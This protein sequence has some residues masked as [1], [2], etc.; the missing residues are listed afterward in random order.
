M[1]I[2][3]KTKEFLTQLKIV[4][5]VVTAKTAI[6]ILSSVHV[7]V[8]N[9]GNGGVFAILQ[10]SDSEIWL[11]KRVPLVAGVAGASFCINA[12]NLHKALCNLEDEELVMK[13]DE[14]KNVATCIYGSGRFSMPYEDAQ[15]YPASQAIMDSADT[16]MV[17][18]SQ[19]LFALNKVFFAIGDDQLRIILNGV[20]FDCYP[21]MMVAVA[22]DSHKLAVYKDRKFKH[23]DDKVYNFTLPEK[24]CCVLKSFIGEEGMVKISVTDK[25]V[26]FSNSNFKLTAR[27]IEGNYPNY[28]IVTAQKGTDVAF[29]NKDWMIAALKRVM[30]MGNSDSQLVQLGFKNEG[31]LVIKTENID[32][33]TSATEAVDC[34]YTGKDMIIGFKASSLIQVLTNIYTDQATIEMSDPT[35]PCLVYE[36]NKDEY[37]SLIMPMLIR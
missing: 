8:V 37:V 26:A 35:R 2:K 22:T 9:D 4:N 13:F 18:G 7:N 3:F 15:A 14:H 30:P 34:E 11:Q 6:P 21:E 12:S 20:H 29:V 25:N 5:T 28:N 19:L 24:A 1:E 31:K 16:F 33:A 10:T 36:C 23:E 17:E 27:L 32:F